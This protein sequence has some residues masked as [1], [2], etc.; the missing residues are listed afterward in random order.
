MKVELPASVGMGIGVALVVVVAAVLIARKLAPALGQAVNPVNPDNVFHS[1]VNA[2]GAAITGDESFSL[3]GWFHDLLSSD[4]AKIEAMKQGA[5]AT[6]SLG[7][8]Q[9]EPSPFGFGA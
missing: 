9:V 5:P 3:G 2:A 8:D 4:N 7:A 6:R 1:G